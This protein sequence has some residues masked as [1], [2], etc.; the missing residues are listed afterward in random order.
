MQRDGIMSVH[1]VLLLPLT[2]IQ[3]SGIR[4]RQIVHLPLFIYN[5]L[6]SSYSV[7]ETYRSLGF[8]FA[9]VLTPWSYR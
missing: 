7:D 4:K 1:P 5:G 9:R 2:I 3:V 6:W 8:D